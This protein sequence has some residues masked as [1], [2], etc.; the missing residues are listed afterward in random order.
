MYK[1]LLV[2]R[3]YCFI[4]FKLQEN[5]GYVSMETYTSRDGKDYKKNKQGRTI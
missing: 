4:H 1:D 5:Y 2:P 3:L